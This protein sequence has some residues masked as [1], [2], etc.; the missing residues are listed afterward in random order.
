[1]AVTSVLEGTVGSVTCVSPKCVST[2]PS[3]EAHRPLQTGVIR[4]LDRLATTLVMR[5]LGP[6]REGTTNRSAGHIASK[7]SFFF[8]MML[9]L[10]CR[11]LVP[12]TLSRPGCQLHLLQFR[13]SGR[14]AWL[15]GNTDSEWPDSHFPKKLNTSRFKALVAIIFSLVPTLILP[16]RLPKK[17]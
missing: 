15:F 12:V 17:K 16:S 10:F 4:S 1:M 9:I 14:C 3:N 13:S 7:T 2:K 5:L 6:P 8:S 11:A